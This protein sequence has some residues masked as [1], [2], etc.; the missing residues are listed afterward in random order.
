MS[1]DSIL[2]LSKNSYITHRQ[3][4]NNK[5]GGLKKKKKVKQQRV[6]F[7]EQNSDLEASINKTKSTN[8]YD[9]L[10]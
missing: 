10:L 9:Q 8:S 7:E 3:I 5:L 6:K 1:R 2:H 4:E